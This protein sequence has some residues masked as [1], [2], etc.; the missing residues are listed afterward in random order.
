MVIPAVLSGGTEELV[1]RQVPPVDGGVTG[2]LAAVMPPPA[3]AGLEHDD[4]D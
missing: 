2:P 4:G 3:L 1:L